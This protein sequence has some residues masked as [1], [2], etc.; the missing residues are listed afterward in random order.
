MEP[1]SGEATAVRADALLVERV[2]QRVVEK[3]APVLEAMAGVSAPQLLDIEEAA[4]RLCISTSTLYKR[5]SKGDIK[6]VKDGSSVAFRAS[7]LDEY[8]EERTHAPRR[9]RELARSAQR[10][11]GQR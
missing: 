1:S 8:I 11:V 10:S 3:L 5:V 4:R 2:A 9:A 6:H 7:H